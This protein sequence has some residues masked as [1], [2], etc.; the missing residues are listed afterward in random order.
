[1]G[2][3][4]RPNVSYRELDAAD[5]T[6]SRDEWRSCVEQWTLDWIASW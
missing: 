6:F 1:M 4:D 5:H 3:L 2:A